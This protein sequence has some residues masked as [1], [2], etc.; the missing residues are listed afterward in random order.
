MLFVRRLGPDPHANGARTHACSGCPDIWE[1]ES[2]D[3]AVIGTDLTEITKSL[4]P[5]ASCGPDERIVR[6]PRKTLVL[7]KADI[8]DQLW[9]IQLLSPSW[10]DGDMW[11]WIVS[12]WFTILSAVVAVASLLFTGVSLRSE[13]KARQ[14]GNLLSLTQNHREIWSLPIRD[15]KLNRVLDLS[16][17]LET[18][19]VTREE[20]IFVNLV[21]QHVSSA[22]QALRRGLDVNIERLD[23][24]VREFFTLPIPAA[25][26]KNAKALQNTSF[27]QFVETCLRGSETK[28][29][30]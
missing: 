30:L 21:I 18:H 25:V 2:G 8:P 23:E 5:S 3:F 19:P 11:G 28:F 13:T 26:W 6:I 4:P 24:D 29:K 7:A 15:S 9:G 14:I 27:I 16:L 22:F 20:R 10:Y 1:L 12:N 17:N